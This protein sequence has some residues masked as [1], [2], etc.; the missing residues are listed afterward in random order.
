M[1]QRGQL[2]A[3]CKDGISAAPGTTP[4]EV[5]RY[6]RLKPIIASCDSDDLLP[7]QWHI[8]DAFSLYPEGIKIH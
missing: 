6:F 7:V 3:F 5:S 1:G 8:N 2:E 4:G